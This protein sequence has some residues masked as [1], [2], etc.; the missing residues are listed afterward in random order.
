M[1]KSLRPGKVLIDWSQNNAAKTT[2]A[3]YSLRARREPTVSTPLM[4]AE[5]EGARNA[6]DLVFRSGDVLERVARDGDLFT[7]LVDPEAD[8]GTRPRLP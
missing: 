6:Q 1:T 2:V 7:A 5:V 4:W 3:P 8:P